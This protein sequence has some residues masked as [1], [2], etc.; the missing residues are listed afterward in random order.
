MSLPLASS[1]SGICHFAIRIASTSSLIPSPRMSRG[2]RVTRFCYHFYYHFYSHSH[3]CFPEIIRYP[4]FGTRDSVPRDSVPRD[5][6]SLLLSCSS[7]LSSLLFS[8]HFSL[9]FSLFLNSLSLL[10]ARR[11]A[12]ITLFVVLL[13]HSRAF[14]VDALNSVGKPMEWD[15]KHGGGVAIM[16]MTRAHGPCIFWNT[17]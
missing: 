5:L 15:A 10:E 4:R 7:P 16:I 6:P 14:S 11:T 12:T 17:T 2:G 3:S 8:L 1:S 13:N 9:H